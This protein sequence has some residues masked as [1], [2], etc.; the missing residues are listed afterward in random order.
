M[1]N[2]S[3]KQQNVSKPKAGQIK[4]VKRQQRQRQRPL[5]EKGPKV[6]IETKKQ[7]RADPRMGV[8]GLTQRL[9]LVSQVRTLVSQVKVTQTNLENWCRG[10]IMEAVQRGGQAFASNPAYCYYAYVYAVKTM[11]SLIGNTPP[12]ATRI[13]HAML[14]AAQG[15]KSK[16]VTFGNGNVNY[17]ATLDDF[18][19][20]PASREV[21]YGSYGYS[22][23]LFLPTQ[24][25][26]NV[27]FPLMSTSV[28]G[29]T[30]T[31]GA[32]AFQQICQILTESDKAFEMTDVGTITSQMRDVSS[33]AWNL[34][35]G[36]TVGLCTDGS[37]VGA[38]ANYT[39][40]L[41]VP[42]RRPMFSTLAS[43]VFQTSLPGRQDNLHA[44]VGGDATFLAVSQFSWFSEDKWEMQRPP[45]FHWI[46]FGEISD[47]A[48]KWISGVQQAYITEKGTAI[49]DPSTVQCPLTFQ[50]FNLILRNVVVQAFKETQCGVH[51]IYP[52]TP[53][54]VNDLQFV[55]FVMSTGTCYL[56]PNDLQIPLFLVENIRS[57]VMRQVARSKTDWEV[58]VPVLGQFADYTFDSSLYT[59]VSG[60][61]T[62]Q[63]FNSGEEVGQV[64]V[65]TKQGK[66][67]R[68]LV[69]ETISLIDGSS[70]SGY[71]A[72]NDPNALKQLTDLFNNWISKQGLGTYSSPMGVLGVDAGI[73]ALTSINMSRIIG[74]PPQRIDKI[75]DKRLAHATKNRSEPNPFYTNRVITMDTS[76]SIMLGAPY[77]QIQS[78]WILPIIS[79]TSEGDLNDT[80]PIRVQGFESEPYSQVRTI[81]SSQASGPSLETLHASYAA[82]M[83]RSE[84]APTSDWDE[85][86]KTLAAQGRGG[87]LTSLVSK[88][89]DAVIPGA[90]SIVQTIGNAIGV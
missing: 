77:E 40:G 46:D 65:D 52:I 48:G 23:N 88:L 16:V 74:P 33:F 20:P 8:N 71:V 55:P 11:S 39:V 44:Q 27:R 42:I 34:R 68:P 61:T 86:F 78:V 75:Q 19:Q 15:L 25:F 90:S 17:T 66:V 72:I 5:A 38:G 4:K 58:F 13:P 62:Y 80:T 35:T 69:E 85:L 6:I 76:Q 49:A 12:L 73:N 28:P 79:I 64:E 53:Q 36:K 2:S 51:A 24:S 84:L 9:D 1:K 29:Y 37:T 45:K 70:S 83:V 26:V 87:I 21:G 47:V 14:A 54:S 43:S 59:Y 31:L 60:S 82:K 67:Y 18:S 81:G 32:A 63:S 10:M 41:E 57:L 50:E 22:W 89:A 3:K 56:A 30:D 7:A